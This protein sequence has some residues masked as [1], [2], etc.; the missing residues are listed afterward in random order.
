MR[1][2]GARSKRDRSTGPAIAVA[3]AILLV[4][5]AVVVAAAARGA[6]AEG[7]PASPPDPAAA[8]DEVD[9]E[10]RGLGGWYTDAQ[11][12]R[13]AEAYAEHCAECHSPDLRARSTYISLFGY[14]ALTGA[15]FWDRWGGQSVHALLLVI[16][17][18]MP[19]HA[20]GTLGGDTYAD[21]A[22]HVLRVNGF[23]SGARELPAAADAVERL[24]AMPIEPDFARPQARAREVGV[25]PP[26]DAPPE[27]EPEEAP[28]EAEDPEEEPPE[29]ET[30]D[31]DPPEEAEDVRDAW[32]TEAQVER[33]RDPYFRHCS[34]CHG[35]TLGGVGVAPS[36][37]G[38]NFMERWDGESVA[39]LFWV[40]SE[41]MP[42][43]D[44]GSLGGRTSADLVAYILAQNG[45]EAGAIELPADEARLQQFVIGEDTEDEDDGS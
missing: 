27:E 45:F 4:L 15:Y 3:N 44:Q 35:V 41:L 38:D 1:E 24:V 8:H 30:P 37:A 2:P 17:E 6:R 28:H 39:D 34:R 23:A 14:P 29:E 10:E 20:P 13:G 36:L 31:G 42:L 32:F 26:E 16:Q 7:P 18:T 22:A 43:D 19:L 12:E 21:I 25:R 11:A 33:A 9:A 40:V 5:V